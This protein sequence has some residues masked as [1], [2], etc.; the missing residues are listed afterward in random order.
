MLSTKDIHSRM[1]YDSFIYCAKSIFL[2][3]CP[4]RNVNGYFY[5]EHR[6]PSNTTLYPMKIWNRE[7]AS[8]IN[9]FNVYD[10]KS[11]AMHVK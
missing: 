7:P 6:K 3:E 5:L 9:Q 4:T 8:P 2:L 11:D 10:C 1:N